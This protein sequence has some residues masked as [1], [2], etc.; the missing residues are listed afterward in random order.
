MDKGIKPEEQQTTTDLDVI[1]KD[2]LRQF[3]IEQP[4]IPGN[5]PPAV[6]AAPPEDKKK[7]DQPPAEPPKRRFADHDKAE[8]GYAHVQAQNTRLAQENSDLKKKLGKYQDDET[9]AQAQSD[10]KEYEDLCALRRN[11]LLEDISALDPDSSDYNFQVA[12]LQAGADRDIME[13]GQKRLSKPSTPQPPK[14]EAPLPPAAPDQ[15]VPPETNDDKVRD[16][17]VSVITKPE[18]GLK[19]DDPLFWTFAAQAPTHDDQ[20]T[21]LSIDEQIAWAVEQRNKTLTPYLPPKDPQKEINDAAA[22]AGAHQA[23]EQ[24]LGRGGG[25]RTVPDNSGAAADQKFSLA[26]AIDSGLERRRL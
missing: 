26:D 15:P 9:Q 1:I 4:D 11:K 7:T 14:E 23:A 13:E 2:N 5:T 20:G 19:A 21:R 10:L 25:Q 22:A 3:D 6:P 12:K 16:Y 8:E 18:I 24:P 17:A